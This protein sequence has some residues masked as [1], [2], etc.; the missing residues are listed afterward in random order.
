MNPW[1][2]IEAARRKALKLDIPWG[3]EVIAR[4]LC[5]FWPLHSAWLV[6]AI[7]REQRAITTMTVYP[8]NGKVVPRSVIYHSA[9]KFEKRLRARRFKGLIR[10]DRAKDDG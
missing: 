1:Q 5:R 4:P 10:H 9:E 8:K 6:T 3:S 7:N 2:V